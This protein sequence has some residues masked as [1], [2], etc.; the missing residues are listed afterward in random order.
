MLVRKQPFS[1][2]KNKKE[3]RLITLKIFDETETKNDAFHS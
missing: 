3:M 2:F 1:I